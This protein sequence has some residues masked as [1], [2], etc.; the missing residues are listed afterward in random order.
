MR[1][2]TGLPTCD[3][4]TDHLLGTVPIWGSFCVDHFQSSSLVSE[5]LLTFLRT[6]QPFQ[7]I[8]AK[9]RGKKPRNSPIMA[10][11]YRVERQRL[12][13]TA[14]ICCSMHFCPHLKP[15]DGTL[16]TNW[17]WPDYKTGFLHFLSELLAVFSFLHSP[18]AGK[19]SICLE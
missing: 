16:G 17:W 18:L 15:L 5:L 7:S 13:T 8:S 10:R 2:R 3:A 4:T 14:D 9:N 11:I 1:A 19:A 12:K 6:A